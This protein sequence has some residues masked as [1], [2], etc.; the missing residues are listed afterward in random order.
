MDSKPFHPDTYVG[1][2]NEEE[3]LQ[4]T[5]N[6]EKSM[7]VKLKVENTVRWRWI[8]DDHGNDVRSR[9]NQSSLP[10]IRP[11]LDSTIQQQS[12]SLVRRLSESAS[13]KGAL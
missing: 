13:R 9:S 2:E 6:R 3:D 5:D 8:K 7:S 12:Y 11:Y 10:I 4:Q 1:P